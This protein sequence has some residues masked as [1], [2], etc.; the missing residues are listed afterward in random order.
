MA[1]EQVNFKPA[2]LG[3]GAYVKAENGMV[4]LTTG[5]HEDDEADNRICLEPKVL[6]S[7][8][9]WLGVKL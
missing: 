9:N 4:I 3:D 1:N 6:E 8:L 2:Y 7:F 5:I